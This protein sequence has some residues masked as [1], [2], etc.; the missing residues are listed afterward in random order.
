[1]RACT[2]C[3]KGYKK[4]AL[5]SHSMQSSIRQLRAN[6][7]WLRLPSGSR[8]KACT[9]CIKSVGKGKID[10]ENIAQKA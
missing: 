4:G 2:I 8:V 9:Q 10:L 6:L 3:G 5:R 1:M 7:Q